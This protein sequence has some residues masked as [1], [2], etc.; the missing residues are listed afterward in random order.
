MV[1]WVISLLIMGAAVMMTACIS[2][3]EDNLAKGKEW[4]KLGTYH[5]EQ[6]Y[7]EWTEQ[8]LIKRG[9]LSETD[10]EKYRAGY[11]QGRS[12]Y[13]RDKRGVNTVVNLD[14][15]DDCNEKETR[16]GLVDRGY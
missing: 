16:S 3:Y 4:T 14:Y 15:P 11:L 7:S 1:R 2:P 6:G 8:D 12:E 9:A 10:Y 5:G 13:C